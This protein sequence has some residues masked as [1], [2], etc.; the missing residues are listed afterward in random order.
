MT[1][2][3]QNIKLFKAYIGSRV[4]TIVFNQY[5]DF[6][7]RSGLLFPGVPV[8]I[9]YYSGGLRKGTPGVGSEAHPQTESEKGNRTLD[10]WEEGVPFQPRGTQTSKAPRQVTGSL[11]SPR[12]TR[13]PPK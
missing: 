3:F 6:C 7:S 5:T 13:A 10:A 12:T 1:D 11:A 8:L 4:T 2:I 9:Q